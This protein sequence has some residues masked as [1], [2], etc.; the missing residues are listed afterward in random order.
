M[1]PFNFSV[2]GKRRVMVFVDSATSFVH[3][4]FLARKSD[5]AAAL[6]DYVTTI[7]NPLVITPTCLFADNGNAFRG[8]VFHR[9][10]VKYPFRREFSSPGTPAQN[11]IAERCNRTLTEITRS[12]FFQSGAPLDLWM[13]AVHTAAYILNRIPSRAQ[14]GR[15]PPQLWSP[16]ADYSLKHMRVWGCPA[17][18]KTDFHINKLALRVSFVAMFP[19]PSLT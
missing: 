8:R 2:G 18:W 14:G 4:S 9:L 17:Y 12:S 19:T 15:V 6:E 13:C 10:S 1:G 5:A 7:L 3:V 11:G 16:A